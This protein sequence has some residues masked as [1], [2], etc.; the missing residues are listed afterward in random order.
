M[1]FL[2]RGVRSGASGILKSFHTT[3]FFLNLNLRRFSVR[4]IFAYLGPSF[5]QQIF[6]VYVFP[7]YQVAD[8]LEKSLPL[9]V[10]LFFRRE[11]IGARAGI[12]HHLRKDHRPAGSQRPPGPPEMKRTR[13]PVPYRL[14]P[15]RLLI[16]RL[17]RQRHFYE[18]LGFVHLRTF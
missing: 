3:M 17:K 10:L 12:I 4:R 14:L 2:N 6:I 8:K 1:F 7:L 16:Y 15:G 18:F 13:M 9:P 11:K 5:F